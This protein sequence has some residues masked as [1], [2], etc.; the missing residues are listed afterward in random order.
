VAVLIALV[1]KGPTVALLMLGVVLLVQQL[2]THVLQPFLMGRAVAL[3][4]LAVIAA[5]A[6]GSFLLGVVGALFAV[7]VLAV[8]NSVTRSYFRQRPR[9]AAPILPS[10]PTEA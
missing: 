5:V 8:A 2:E 4:P 1:V 10:P 9:A 6:L 7:P 3:H